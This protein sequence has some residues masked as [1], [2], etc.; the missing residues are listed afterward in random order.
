MAG[1]VNFL[2]WNAKYQSVPK[3][4]KAPHN[5]ELQFMLAGIT[6][7]AI[8][9]KENVH[10]RMS[11]TIEKMLTERPH[12]PKFQGPICNGAPVRRL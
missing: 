9:K 8:G 2:R 3:P 5:V 7:T 4:I 11:Q 12:L 6:G 10:V 1:P